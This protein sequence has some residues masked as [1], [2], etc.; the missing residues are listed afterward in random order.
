MFGPKPFRGWSQIE[1]EVDAR[2]FVGKLDRTDE[3][4]LLTA[5]G[6]MKTRC[7]RR[8]E[9]DNAWDLQFL[10]LCVGSP[11]NATARSTQQTPTIQQKDELESGRRAKIL[12]LRQNILDK[13]GRT[14]E[15]PG[16]LGIGQH[17][18]ECRGRIE[19]EMVNTVQLSSRHLEIRK[20]LCQNLMSF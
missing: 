18:V 13:Y 11:W 3:F 7:V 1:H 4:L 9:G 17:A 14:A 16:C 10:N 20:K 15:C 6:A 2:V 19:Q 8:L 12:H 5:T